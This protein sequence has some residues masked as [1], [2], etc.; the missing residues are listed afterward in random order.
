MIETIIRQYE[1]LQNVHPDFRDRL[2]MKRRS[3]HIISS[4]LEDIVAAYIYDYLN[5]QN[6]EV[7]INQTFFY[8]TKKKFNPDITI[9]KNDGDQKKIVGLIEVKDSANS[10]RW[11]DNE[12]NNN[13]SIIYVDK[14]IRI[15]NSIRNDHN[16][17]V[18]YKGDN[19]RIAIHIDENL[20]INLALISNKLFSI[21]N[22][23][24]LREYCNNAPVNNVF[25]LHILFSGP[26]P[27]P[28]KSNRRYTANQLIE[29]IEDDQLNFTSFNASLDEIS[30][31]DQ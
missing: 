26:H 29:R 27:N 14:R 24:R 8:T 1:K 21:A 9:V 23:Q 6:I 13:T 28:H 22:H 2:N 18:H 3:N 17:I 11:E 25:N 4:Y 31:A 19:G 16:S 5:D 10:F 7:W 15:L 12:G 20:K 30:R